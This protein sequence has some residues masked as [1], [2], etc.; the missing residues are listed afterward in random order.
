MWSLSL[1]LSTSASAYLPPPFPL[2][3]SSEE[4]LYSLVLFRS[5][6]VRCWGQTMH[7][8][9]LISISITEQHARSDGCMHR[10]DMDK[11]DMHVSVL[12]WNTDEEYY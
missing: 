7:F 2:A 10:V 5:Q 9:C 12:M 6:A 3:S 1:D 11:L 8:K 4:E